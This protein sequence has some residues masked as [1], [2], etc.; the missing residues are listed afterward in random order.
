MWGVLS[1][2]VNSAEVLKP[3]HTLEEKE[4]RAGAGVGVECICI[5]VLVMW[6]ITV[7]NRTMT[8]SRAVG[9]EAVFRLP[10]QYLVKEL[11]TLATHKC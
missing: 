4:M 10:W 3:F 11:L 6:D 2:H 5:L 8:H 7:D 9:E 1:I